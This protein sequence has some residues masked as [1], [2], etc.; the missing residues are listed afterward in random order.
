MHLGEYP[1]CLLPD[2]IPI[3]LNNGTYL[4]TGVGYNKDAAV[5]DF[6]E[7]VCNVSQGFKFETPV[8]WTSPDYLD[9]NFTDCLDEPSGICQYRF[10][11][12]SNETVTDSEIDEIPIET[13]INENNT[14]INLT[15]TY[16]L[17]VTSLPLTSFI[18]FLIITH[19]FF[20]HYI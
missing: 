10:N 1:Q 9:F 5:C 12:K 17:V 3:Y 4:S 14:P 11:I 20:I 18:T 7:P 6:T 8:F 16:T 13:S 19:S 15:T 2:E